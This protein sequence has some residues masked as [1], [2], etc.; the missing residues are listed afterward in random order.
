MARAHVRPTPDFL[1]R[2]TEAMKTRNI[3]FLSFASSRPLNA[4]ARTLPFP[5]SRAHTP[6]CLFPGR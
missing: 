2:A 3:Q 4:R 6:D 5:L 1:T